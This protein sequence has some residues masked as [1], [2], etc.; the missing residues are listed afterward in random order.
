MRKPPKSGDRGRPA[1]SPR[2]GQRSHRRCA[3][4]YSITAAAS[5]AYL[6]QRPPELRRRGPGS[7]C[8]TR[9]RS[10]RPPPRCDAVPLCQDARQASP[11]K[12]RRPPQSPRPVNQRPPSPQFP[13]SLSRRNDP[14]ASKRRKKKARPRRSAASRRRPATSKVPRRSRPSQ[15]SRTHRTHPDPQ[16]IPSNRTPSRPPSA[17]RTAFRARLGYGARRS[18]R[19]PQRPRRSHLGRAS[20]HRTG[21]KR[22]PAVRAQRCD[23]SRFVTADPLATRS[24]THRLRRQHRPDLRPRG[25]NRVARA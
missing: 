4:T 19:G 21:R 16:V 20:R 7:G 13:L 12:R 25:R 2:P 8:R 17:A 1:P 11:R 10:R 24:A 6:S 22:S 23:P 3:R 14:R 15:H 9:P 5:N 18:R